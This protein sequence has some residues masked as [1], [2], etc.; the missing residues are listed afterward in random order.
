MS[1]EDAAVGVVEEAGVMAGAGAVA[2][3]EAVVVL[4]DLA[5]EVRVVGEQ[6]VAGSMRGCDEPYGNR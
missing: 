6:V 1:L 4:A 2:D 5:E 3:L